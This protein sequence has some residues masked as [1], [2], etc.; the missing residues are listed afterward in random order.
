MPSGAWPSAAGRP[1]T[2]TASTG[3]PRASASVTT[4]PYVSPRDAETS[5]SAWAYAA[6]RSGPV[7]APANRI[8]SSSRGRRAA[9][10]SGSRVSEPT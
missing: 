10:K 2:R 7:S 9:T 8:R 4:I 3:I 6:A 1:P 5:R